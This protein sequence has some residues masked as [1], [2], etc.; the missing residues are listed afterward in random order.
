MFAE[1]IKRAQKIAEESRKQEI[2][3]TY[4]LGIAKIALQLQK[5]EAPKFHNDFV[6]LGGFHIK[7]EAFAIFRKYIAESWGP[8]IL[9]D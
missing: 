6:A 3:V 4:N 7:M 1:I 2:C 9:N 5:E 8:D